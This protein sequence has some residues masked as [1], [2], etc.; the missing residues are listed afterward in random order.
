MI[1]E[2]LYKEIEKALADLYAAKKQ[3]IQ[4][5]VTR[6]EFDGDITLVVFPL[7]SASKKNPE[8]T[9]NDIGNY[10]KDNVSEVSGFNVVKGFLNIEI[11]K[12]FWFTQ[13]IEIYNTID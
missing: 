10:L 1:Q 7:L 3:N 4:L 12:D 5:Q 9:A 11:S 6:R 2:I 8:E 13:F